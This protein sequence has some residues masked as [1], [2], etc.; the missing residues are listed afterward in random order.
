LL[1]LLGPLLNGNATASAAQAPVVVVS[2]PP[3]RTTEPTAAGLYVPATG[4][5][6][7][8]ADTLAAIERGEV[9]N[10]L[11]GGRPKGKPK[12]HVSFSAPRS[13]P[14][15]IIYL[16]V[17]PPGRHHNVRR[18]RIWIV[19]AGSGILTSSSTRI[20]G[21]VAVTDIAD[22]AHAL[23]DRRAG[24][25]HV[26]TGTDTDL[27]RLDRRLSRAHDVRSDALGLVVGL[28][29][30]LLWDPVAVRIRPAERS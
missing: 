30:A 24:S 10:A 3:P 13:R 7:T 6:V 2:Q 9:E 4:A 18:Y 23:G 15:G 25:M 22:E 1:V 16:T 17:P 11:L 5:T 12:I 14:H 21:L 26:T 27:L 20:R 19:G 8:R 28:L 29:A